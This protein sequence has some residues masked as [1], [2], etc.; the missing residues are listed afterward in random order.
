MKVAITGASGFL[1]SHCMAA[2]VA[3]G[4]EVRVVVRNPT[5]V[6][7]AA[8]LHDL[9]P[10]G[11]EV[12]VADLTDHEA[13]RASLD[14]VDSLLHAGAVFSLDPRQGRQMRSV[15]PTST[16]TLL[17]A[18]TE[19]GLQRVVHVSSL[20]VYSASLTVL[21]PD[22]PTGPECGPYTGSKIEAD[23]VAVAHQEA[24][25]PV[26]VVCP[27]GIIGPLDPSPDL[28][29]SMATVL[30]GLQRSRVPMP[31]GACFGMVDVRDVAAVCVGSLTAGPAPARHLLAGHLIG[32]ADMLRMVSDLTG[33]SIR[34][35]NF[36]APLLSL[37]GVLCELVGRATGR[38][39]PLGRE[40]ARMTTANM[41]VGGLQEVDQR[42][43]ADAFGFPATPLE[44]TLVET[45]SWLHSA[46]HL[47]DAQVGRLAP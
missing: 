39:M 3:A 18:A 30:D 29:D 47:T 25:L 14:G 32:P 35:S 5:K 33:R 23:A 7:A 21:G 38:R 37:T 26:V 41:A 36:P 40:V 19:H 46:G 42:S 13:L 43:A 44:T 15:N 1:G 12:V 10:D 28:S 27:G 45:M 9:D 11:I 20:G 24:G 16:A 31:S 17:E 22:T 6:R 4:H 8:V 34:I 2:A